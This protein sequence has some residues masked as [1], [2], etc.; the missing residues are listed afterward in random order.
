[1]GLLRWWASIR[2]GVHDHHMLQS[3]VR[4]ARHRGEYMAMGS[5]CAWAMGPMAE[6]AGL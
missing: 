6:R 4:L 3:T 5:V 2:D 1:M